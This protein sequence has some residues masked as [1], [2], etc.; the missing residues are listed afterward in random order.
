M[1]EELMVGVVLIEK[2]PRAALTPTDGAIACLITAARLRARRL[3][4]AAIVAC[5]RQLQAQGFERV[6]AEWV[7][8]V[9]HYG[10]LG[11][12]IWKTRDITPE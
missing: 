9:A 5:C 1:Q 4:S 8:S 11:F 3:G 7:W 10:R 12:R 2:Y 6:R